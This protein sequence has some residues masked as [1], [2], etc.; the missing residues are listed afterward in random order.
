[1]NLTIDKKSQQVMNNNWE[2]VDGVIYWK[3]SWD[4]DTA[5]VTLHAQPVPVEIVAKLMHV[6]FSKI[7]K[8]GEQHADMGEPQPTGDLE[9]SGDGT[10]ESQ[11]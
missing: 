10:G 5:I 6:K 7:A 8:Y 9:D 11:E 2:I 3:G 4:G 1:M